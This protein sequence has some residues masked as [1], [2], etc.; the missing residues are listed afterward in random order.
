MSDPFGRGEV[1]GKKADG[2]AD[3]INKLLQNLCITCSKEEGI[4]NYFYVGVLGYG[5]QVGPAFGGP[6]TGKELVSVEELASNPVRID[7]R[8]KKSPDGAG[9]IIEEQ[10]RFPI[11]FDPLANGGTPMCQALG[12]AQNTLQGWLTQHPDCFPP[13][14]INFTDGEF[15]EG[16]PTAKADAL[17]Q[18]GSSDGRILLFNAHLSSQRKPPVEFP[19]NESGLPDQYAKLLFRMSS[20]LTPFMRKV[21]AEKQ[22]VVT[23]GSRGFVFNADLTTVID[24][25]DIGTR[26][27]NLR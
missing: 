6:L 14:V 23:E 25:L 24:F 20:P 9:G 22:Y 10:V 17:T 3:A 8:T 12:Q 4:R 15:T 27:S 11:W 26:P 18:L 19:D 21:A 13:I 1:T 16:D 5:A 7:M 2:V